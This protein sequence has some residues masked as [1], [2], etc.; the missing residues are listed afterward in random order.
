M[1][2]VVIDGKSNFFLDQYPEQA[3]TELTPSATDTADS[4]EALDAI[5]K[6]YETVG[7]LHRCVAIRADAMLRVPWAVMRGETDVWTNEMPEPPE[8]M[9]YLKDFRRLLR[10]TEMALC[11]S[12]EAFWFRERNR[13]RTLSFK[14][15]APSSVIPQWSATDG[16]TGFKRMLGNGNTRLFEVDDYVYF[17]L[18]NPLHET[19]PGRPPAQAAMAAAGVLYNVDAFASSFFKRG[20]IKATLLTIEGNPPPGEL[21]KLES[22]WKR[23]FA[24]VAQ[25]WQ[26]AAVRAGVT[27]VIIGEGIESLAKSDLTREHKEDI[28]TALGIPHSLVMSDA[29][30][31]SVAETDDLHFYDKT[32]IPAFE[33]I[34]ETLNEQVFYPTG[35]RMELRPQKMSIYQEDEEQRSMSVLHYTQASVPVEIAMQM[36]GVDLPAGM[37]Y[38]TFGAM[39]AELR[40]QQSAAAQMIAQAQSMATPPAEAD[41]PDDDDEDEDEDEDEEEEEDEEDEEDDSAQRA[42]RM[43]EIKRLKL[44]AKKRKYPNAD[45]FVSDLLTPDE[46]RAVVA[47][48]SADADFFT[49]IPLVKMPS[50]WSGRS[51][52]DAADSIAAW[53]QVLTIGED[54][55][56]D[57]EQRARDAIERI[58]ADNIAE[59]LERQRRA[60]VPAN[61][62]PANAED[63]VN[64]VEE[65]SGTVRDAL[66]RMLI[67]SVDLGVSVAIAQFD[68]IGFGFDWTLANTAA[69]DWAN[70]YSYELIRGINDTTRQ[71]IRQ[72]VSEWI[73]NGDP[74]S[75]LVR[76]LAPTFGRQRASLIASTEVTRAYAEANRRAYIE[77]GV[78]SQM[79][80]RTSNDERV[81]PICAPLGGLVFNT[82]GASP[83][84]TDQQDGQGVRASLTGSFVH[85]GG[86]GAANRF[87]GQSFSP[88]PAHPRCRCWIVPVIDD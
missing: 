24:G 58:A 17:S 70:A 62:P 47:E 88:P 46:K 83:V 65:T 28:A 29:A 11:L 15:H 33:M 76:E 45:D 36:L 31:R 48:V 40:A 20:A 26:T 73:E 41:E 37:D 25:A 50:I 16:L 42:A 72:A 56:D 12:P 82:G 69:R 67:E 61:S 44:W 52:P 27:P 5:G 74:L 53:K 49:D 32:V 80:W 35:H 86:G 54:D 81:C 87:L 85:P 43:A 77:S 71:Q 1:K 60:L 8:S 39:M 75:V 57:A 84:S 18:P 6:Y 55:D 10:L 38:E 51:I 63:V 64:R 34:V 14:W 19:I 66:R 9:R 78:V 68:T 2:H 3:W 4:R 59:A 22:W 13:A 21:L 79:Q 30:N 7:F 23:A